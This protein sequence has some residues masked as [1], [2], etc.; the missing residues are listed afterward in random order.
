M[1]KKIFIRIGELDLDEKGQIAFL[2]PLNETHVTVY[3]TIPFD[4]MKKPAFNFYTQP[5][6][7]EA[8]WK[9]V[10][11][12]ILLVNGQWFLEELVIQI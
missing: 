12:M 9:F 6:L 7:S 10:L 3:Q 11:L 8:I 4:G 2:R 5:S 1:D